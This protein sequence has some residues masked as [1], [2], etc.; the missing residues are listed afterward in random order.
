[1]QIANLSSYDTAE[2][3]RRSG[4]LRQHVWAGDWLCVVGIA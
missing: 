3:D 1:M 4:R 2:V